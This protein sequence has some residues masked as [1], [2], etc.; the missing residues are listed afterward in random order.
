MANQSVTEQVKESVDIVDLISEYVDLEKRGSNYLGLCPFHNEN[1]PSFNVN[2]EKGFYYC[3][4]CQASGSVIDFYKEM[5]N[6]SFSEALRDLGNRA[7]LKIKYKQENINSKD[8]QLIKM[9]EHLVDLYHE[10]LTETKEG[11]TALKY[12]L[13][14]GF[15]LEQIKR[16]KIGLSP[17]MSDGTIKVLEKLGY[18]KEMM[19][20]AGLV[21]R[22]EETF[23]YFDRFRNRIMIPIK[24]HKGRYVAFTARALGDD[25]PKYLNSPETDIFHKS[26]LIFNLSD[27]YKVIQ[28]RKEV[29]MME[30]HMDVLKVK[31]TNIKNVV[32]TMGTSVSK[33][34]I[35]ILKR[36]TQNITL[37]F[38]GDKAG[39]NAT[40]SVGEKIL[41]MQ[42]NPYV[43]SLPSGMDPDEYI[44]KYGRESFE[45]YI[46]ENRDHFILYDAKEK[47]KDS[48]DNDL[49]FTENLNRSIQ[50]LK[51]VQNEVE[52]SRILRG[53]SDL[54]EI[55]ADLIKRQLPKRKNVRK[56]KETFHRPSILDV[57]SREFKERHIIHT[58]I[59]DK[60]TL[61]TFKTK[62]D[63]ELFQTEG[64]YGIIKNLMEYFSEF[65]TFDKQMFL[66]Y[67]DHEQL[68]NLERILDTD[69][70]ILG[71]SELNDY[72]NAISGMSSSSGEKNRLIKEIE[73]AELIGDDTR[74]LELF[75]QLI[76]LQKSPKSK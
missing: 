30:G 3:F 75:S 46:K 45:N 11:E 57:T 33:E 58:F 17:N 27:S 63:S 9:H 29:I 42:A 48:K 38:D 34:Q 24:N 15:T 73:Q 1:T 68:S 8:L 21:A 61:E 40:T 69:L 13:D 49:M 22:N 76:E 47:L 52:E 6:L 71:E 14:R 65:D 20:Q 44:E 35:E 72:V 74:A 16:E 67:I 4:G 19:Y 31:G 12:L 59:N 37:M 23:Q 51:Y 66:S 41:E 28:D 26:R 7:G 36:V 32:G 64:Y 62:L 10:I 25:H 43:I 53:L 56:P 60:S 18:S 54:Y 50:L 55:E 5:E 2:R 39:K 70:P